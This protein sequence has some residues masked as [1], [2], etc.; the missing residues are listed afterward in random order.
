MAPWGVEVH[1]GLLSCLNK[2]LVLVLSNTA[3][4][5]V[6]RSY[7][8]DVS[9]LLQAIQVMREQR[10]RGHIFNMDGAGADGNATP[11]FSAYGATKRGLAQLGKSLQVRAPTR[12]ACVR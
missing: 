4:F 9:W 3:Y 5:W 12:Q 7:P 1:Q 2:G 6:P 10:S 8:V 11:L